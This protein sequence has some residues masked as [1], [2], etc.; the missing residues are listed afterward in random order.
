MALFFYA[1]FYPQA[2][3]NLLILLYTN[4]DSGNTSL[5]PEAKAQIKCVIDIIQI[6]YLQI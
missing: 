4:N 6:R 5:P 2:L 3:S 1:H